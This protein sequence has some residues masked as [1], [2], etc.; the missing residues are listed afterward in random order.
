M[1]NEANNWQKSWKTLLRAHDQRL[2]L[3]GNLKISLGAFVG[4]KR[5][6]T[7][8]T[9]KLNRFENRAISSPN[10]MPSTYE[11]IHMH[12][13]HPRLSVLAT[14]RICCNYNELYEVYC[15]IQPLESFLEVKANPIIQG[16][17]RFHACPMPQ[18]LHSVIHLVERSS[19]PLLSSRYTNSDANVTTGTW[20]HKP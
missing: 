17:G 18:N 9:I 8:L 3:P 10:D 16:L 13:S 5:T 19:R 12:N 7:R 2:S 6:W 1:S 11:S 14:P 15:A 4:L 20:L